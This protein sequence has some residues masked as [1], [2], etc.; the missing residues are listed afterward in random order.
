MKVF[1][2][3]V[4]LA[5]VCCIVLSCAMTALAQEDN[6]T[7]KAGESKRGKG[8]EVKQDQQAEAYAMRKSITGGGSIKCYIWR[9]NPGAQV[10][11]DHTLAS[12]GE[13]TVKY[14]NS[15]NKQ[16]GGLLPNRLEEKWS[17]Y[18]R[19]NYCKLYFLAVIHHIGH[20]GRKEPVSMA[21]QVQIP[22]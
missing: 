7:I 12:D 8:S 13:Y 20:G 22:T 14:K 1:R 4:C 16:K 2:S 6:C 21:S 17:I 18:Q 5:L 3:F 15:G 10:T 19:R 11:D 9:L